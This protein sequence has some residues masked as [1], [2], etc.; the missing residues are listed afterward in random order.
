MARPQLALA[1]TALAAAIRA[2]AR[3]SPAAAAAAAASLSQPSSQRRPAA[4][5]SR[6][7]STSPPLTNAGL[8]ALHQRKITIESSD[9]TTKYQ[10]MVNQGLIRDD[11]HQRS[12]VNVLQRLHEE[13]KTYKQIPPKELTPDQ[14]KHD[15]N[16]KKKGFFQSLFGGGPDKDNEADDEYKVPE[17]VPKGLYLYGDVGTGKSMLMDLFYETLPANITRARR[18]HFHQFMIDAHKRAHAIKSLTHVPSGMVMSAVTAATSTVR[19]AGPAGGG[20]ERSLL[21]RAGG[22][23][24]ADPIGPTARELAREYEVLCFDEFQ[25]TDIADAM[26]MRKLLTTM[27]AHGVVF[28]MTSNRHPDNLYK[29]GIQRSS[30]VPCIEALKSQLRVT[31]LNSGTDYRKMPRA[32]SNVYFSPPTAEATREYEKIFDAFTSDPSDPLLENRKVQVWGRDLLV[33]RS[34]SSVARFTFQELC[35]RPRAAA[36]YIELCNTFSTVFV[37]GIPQMGIHQRDVARRLITFI[38]AAY[39]AKTKLLIT[40]EV[41]VLQIFSGNPEKG[42]TRDQMRALMDDLGLTMDDIGGSPIFTGEEELFAFARVI[43]RLTEMSS[44]RW[45]EFSGGRETA[46]KLNVGSKDEAQ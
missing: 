21:N 37:D 22:S 46:G 30:F 38:D 20:T 33:P 25:V 43:S 16:K 26:I 6:P 8:T 35:G 12:I 23:G 2:G 19:S 31:D 40:S 13:L 17:D 3:S 34:T 5:P 14:I 4:L 11:P 15:L 32:L 29:N 39:E 41:P 10:L 1:R 45:A 18:I 24:E 27:M 36:D 9:P 28:V 42:P 44:Q 7:L